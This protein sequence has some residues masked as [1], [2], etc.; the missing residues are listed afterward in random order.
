MLQ[1]NVGGV[2]GTGGSG[3]GG[4][5]GGGNG[6]TDGGG[7]G[8][9]SDIRVAPYG[10]ANMLVAAGGAAAALQITELQIRPRW[11]RRRIN[12]R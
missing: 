10:V 5:N 1:V 7:G 4:F 9:G 3:I 12:R 11:R 6:I 8:G 2:G